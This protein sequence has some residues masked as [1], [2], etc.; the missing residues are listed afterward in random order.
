MKEIID[1]IEHSNINYVVNDNY[2]I[3]M[4]GSILY[5][6]DNKI[7]TILI[8]RLRI[9]FKNLSSKERY[10]I[11]NHLENKFNISIKKISGILF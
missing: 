7:I 10:I 3:L 5:N 11:K 4:G 6:S 9:I 1:I 8:G 2:L